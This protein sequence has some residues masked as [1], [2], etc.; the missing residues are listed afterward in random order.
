MCLSEAPRLNSGASFILSELPMDN[1]KIIDSKDSLRSYL[2]TL[3]EEKI[4]WID[5]ETTSLHVMEADILVVSIY[6][7]DTVPVAV[8]VDSEYF[9][10]VK[11]E[12]I[13]EYLNPVLEKH[14][15]GGHNFKYD[16]C[17]MQNNGFTPNINLKHD[18]ST[19]MHL[20]DPDLELN[21]EKAV[22]R[23]LKINKP[24]FEDIIG[25]RWNTIL[26]K[27][28]KLIDEGKITK[29]NYGK[30]ACEDVYYCQPIF[31]KYR[32]LILEDRP[33]N[34]I[35]E[36]IEMPLI[37]PLV[38]AQLTGVLIDTD[39][40]G[41][42]EK[43][44][45]S[46]ISEE[47]EE[48]Y[49]IAGVEFNV[50]STKQKAEV[51]FNR[52]GYPMQGV[53]KSGQPKTDEKCLKTLSDLGYPIA[54]SMLK[55]SEYSKILNTYILGIPK[56]L[57]P[58]NTLH[59][60]LN[61][62]GTRTLRFSS[63]DPNLQNV[64]SDDKFNI[65]KSFI[66][67]PG[68]VFVGCDY[69]AQEYAIAAHASGDE[70]MIAIFKEGKDIHQWVADM[71]GITRKQAK[72]V[73]FGIFYGLSVKNLA[74]TLKTDSKTAQSYI[75]RYYEAFPRLRLWKEAVENYALRNKFIRTPVGSIRRFPDISNPS[76]IDTCLR[77]AV[78]T[79]I[80]GSAAAQMKRAIVLITEEFQ[81]RS[82]DATLLLSIHDEVIV[83]CREGIVEQV[84]QIVKYNM[85]NAIPFKARFWAEPNVVRN[86]GD[87]KDDSKNLRYQ[88]NNEAIMN[89]MII[90]SNQLN[91][92]YG[93]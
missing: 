11:L 50:N 33:L 18:T 42:K 32:A 57:T 79:C 46:A 19:L 83:E 84:C 76:F 13:I 86:Y 16:W 2:K 27:L 15:I 66:A 52:L 81:K 47:K 63:S 70:N 26:A 73:G 30:Y 5:T 49:Q 22:S 40:L 8:F 75:D 41:E 12:Y 74:L 1:F 80:Q 25:F 6:Q 43:E 89:S 54:D 10:G 71:C 48:I 31:E 4:T 24:T 45:T 37:R 9:E 65:R 67:R 7:K 68:Y 88:I 64:A 38:K 87:V 29:F 34:N 91:K 51:L 55:V 82:L 62:N 20:Y 23:D 3:T 17:V 35:Y 36:R 69:S 59:G 53:T 61:P 58:K 56:L 39:V 21:L 28:Q 85:E 90:N 60:N 72:T 14:Q 93:T 77:R 78:N 92:Y 44:L